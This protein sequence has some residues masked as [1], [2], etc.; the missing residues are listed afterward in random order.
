M[1]KPSHLLPCGRSNRLAS[2]AAKPISA[3]SALET[4]TPASRRRSLTAPQT[5]S[6]VPG[7]RPTMSAFSLGPKRQRLLLRRASHRPAVGKAACPAIYL[8]ENV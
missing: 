8:T 4:S 2:G 7:E 5:L 6:F 1:Q 3:P